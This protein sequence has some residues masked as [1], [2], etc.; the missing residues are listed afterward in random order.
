VSGVPA[1][2]IQGVDLP[3]ARGARA[4]FLR[5]PTF[6]TDLDVRG[7]E[8]LVRP[9]LAGDEEA[10]EQAV[11]E[12][13]N[14]VQLADVVGRTTAHL[15][16]PRSY[17]LGRL[18]VPLD[19]ASVVLQ[20]TPA[21]AADMYLLEGVRRLIRDGH[22]IA[23]SGVVGD[24]EACR[25]LLE[26]CSMVKV[27]IRRARPA[28]LPTLVRQLRAYPVSVVALGVDS[29][30]ELDRARALGFDLFQGQ[31][32]IRVPA[33]R[34][35]TLEPS[36][37]TC[38]R[39][40][41]MLSEP[42]AGVA[43]IEAAVR[44]DPGLSLR[45]LRAVNSAGVGLS[46]RVSSLRQAI[47]L[48]GRRNL[49]SWVML[50]TLASD[51]G[52]ASESVQWA[53]ARARLC[54]MLAG[55]SGAEADAAFVVGLLASMDLLIGAPLEQLLAEVPIEDYLRDAVLHREGALGSAL[56][57]ATAYL[58]GDFEKVQVID[59]YG[60]AAVRSLALQAITWATRTLAPHESA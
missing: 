51:G 56:A 44:V 2:D 28:L 49:L 1:R 16:L 31:L 8:L 45:V 11:M 35:H 5:Q 38:V 29:M 25:P 53:L 21:A 30:G 42:D 59:S 39:L 60:P 4:H 36:H 37:M 15:E 48:L 50:M 3:S 46:N 52:G 19:P 20:V 32:L 23:L 24:I 13:V 33:A 22:R 34:G 17:V 27:D 55:R 26:M 58:S 6:G 43:E 10:V 47:V 14:S 40:V 9:A 7:Y 18:Q 12:T 57:D 41:A 54:E